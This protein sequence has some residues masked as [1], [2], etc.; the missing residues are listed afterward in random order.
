MV[1]ESLGL[2]IT[3]EEFVSKTTTGEIKAHIGFEESATLIV[4][5]LRDKLS[6]FE[7]SI[8][9]IVSK[10]M[11]GHLIKKEFVA[12][13]NHKAKAISKNNIT[14]EFDLLLH[15]NLIEISL[16]P[17]DKIF[18]DGDSPITATFSPGF[19]A[20]ETTAANIL[21]NIELINGYQPGLWRGTDLQPSKV[22]SK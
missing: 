20:H 21:N 10:A 18:L 11:D 5:G 12:G 9:P 13:F 3:E 7:E 17:I 8:T 1:W 2:N 15:S 16:E 4:E 14:L 19:N 6:S 22:L